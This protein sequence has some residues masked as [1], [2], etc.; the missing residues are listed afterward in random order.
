[1]AFTKLPIEKGGIGNISFPLLA[2]TN[3]NISKAYG[4]YIY[5]GPDEGICS[6]LTYLIDKEGYVIGIFNNDTPVGTNIEDILQTL[7]KIKE[8]ENS[9]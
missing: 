9:E 8:H 7:Q 4:A 1:M 6:R 3:R 2:D 5:D